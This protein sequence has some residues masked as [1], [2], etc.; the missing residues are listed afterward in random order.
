MQT[1]AFKQLRSINVSVMSWAQNWPQQLQFKATVMV[2]KGYSPQQYH[3]YPYCPCAAILSSHEHHLVMRLQTKVHQGRSGRAK[4][5]RNT[6]SLG[7]VCVTWHE[8]WNSIWS[9]SLKMKTKMYFLPINVT[10]VC[11]GIF[12][13]VG[14]RLRYVTLVSHNTFVL[15]WDLLICLLN[16]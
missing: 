12:F 1:R 2:S 10:I 15:N 3:R 7:V 16:L 6:G 13:T 8:G 4:G 9:Y 11:L 5:V 14:K